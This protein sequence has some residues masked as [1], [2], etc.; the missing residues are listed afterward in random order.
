[1]LFNVVVQSSNNN[2]STENYTISANTMSTCI[3]YFE[4][5]GKKINLI[6]V[7]ENKN[8]LINNPLSNACYNVVLK[9]TV[10]NLVISYIIYDTYEN[11]LNWVT[12]Q[13][14]FLLNSFNYQPRIFMSI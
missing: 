3:S 12:Q 14:G 6:N 7:I 13:S 9:N 8:I 2:P 5:L 11:S 1:M 10:T 4:E